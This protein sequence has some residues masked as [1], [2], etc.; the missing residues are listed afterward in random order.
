MDKYTDI[1]RTRFAFMDY[2]MIHFLSAKTRARVSKLLPL[3]KQAAANHAR[4]IP[5]REL[6]N[7]IREAYALNPPPSDKGRRL[8]I[9]FATQ[10]H[11][12]PPGFVLFCNDTELVH[13]SY[14]RYIENKL[15]ETYAFEGTPINIYFRQRTKVELVDRPMRIRRVLATGKT[16]VV[17]RAARKKSTE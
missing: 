3:I 12:S 6:N 17:R 11:V 4:R 9:F 16:R 15:R 8:K 14:K 10:P 13:F 1:I 5:T 2:A 7:L